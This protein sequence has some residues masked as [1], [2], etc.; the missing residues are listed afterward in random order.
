MRLVRSP[1]LGFFKDIRLEVKPHWDPP[2]SIILSHHYDPGT[3]RD[4]DPVLSIHP[5]KEARY[6]YKR[7]G[8]G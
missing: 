1:S 8:E 4:T 2:G 5:L 7:E 3:G 6:A